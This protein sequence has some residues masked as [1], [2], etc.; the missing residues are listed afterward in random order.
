MRLLTLADGYGDSNAVPPWYKKYYK[1]PEIIKLMTRGLVLNNVS[2]YGAGNEYIVNQ[3]NQNIH[4]TDKVMIQWAM[5][6]RFDLVLTDHPSQQWQEIIASDPVYGKILS[7]VEINNFGSAVHPK[8]Q[9]F[10][11]IITNIFHTN[12][13]N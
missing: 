9:L 13:I 11:S 2:R 3:L 6:N 5:P 7:V 8:Y 12:N 10:K 1:W 4:S